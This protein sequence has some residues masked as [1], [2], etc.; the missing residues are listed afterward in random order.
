MRW[1]RPAYS[2]GGQQK[3]LTQN[4]CGAGYESFCIAPNGDVMPCCAFHMPIGNLSSQ[5]LDT[6]LQSPKL[7]EWRNSTLKEFEDCGTHEYCAYCNL[8]PG[9]GFSEHG[10]WRRASENC[11]YVAKI[12]YDV[13]SKMMDGYDPLKGESIDEA[14]KLFKDYEDVKIK[15]E[16]R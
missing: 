15:R 11:C 9:L 12:R 1:C 13:A 8:C 16:T 2:R 14:I 4:G 3:D 10:D 6:I 5:D 7:A